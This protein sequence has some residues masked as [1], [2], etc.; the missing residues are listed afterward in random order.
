[1]SAD[2]DFG[3]EWIDGVRRIRG[4]DPVNTEDPIAWRD[5]RTCEVIC[6]VNE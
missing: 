3:P 4:D 6:R 5:A 1:M 2:D